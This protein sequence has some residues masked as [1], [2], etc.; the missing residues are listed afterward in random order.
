MTVFLFK[1]LMTPIFIGLVTLAGRRWGPAV[2]GLLMGLPLTSGP[3]SV[4]LLLQYGPA[5]AARAAVGNMVGQASGCVF[6]L[7]YGLAARKWPWTLCA[8]AAIL[9]FFG[10][11]ALLDRFSWTLFSA[12]GLLLGAIIV[13][14]R[15]LPPR[16]FAAVPADPPR[17]DLPARM[18]VA[19]A[20]VLALTACARSLGPQLSGLI[21]PFPIY[22]LVVAAFTQSRQGTAAVAGLLRANVLGSLA[23][24]AFFLIAGGCLGHAPVVGVYGLAAL[25]SAGTG[26]AAF[27]ASRNRRIQP[28]CGA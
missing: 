17:W 18:L 27:L 28:R 15:L 24:I 11:T 8:P 23:F 3:I 9:A 6:C 2:S 25:A 19:T 5:F 4:F 21:A 22:G 13:A 10:S 12:A 26:G 1:L 14:H 7:T 20:F 16:P